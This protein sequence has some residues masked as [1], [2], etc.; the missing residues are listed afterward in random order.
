MAYKRINEAFCLSFC[1]LLLYHTQAF[2]DGNKPLCGFFGWSRS[3]SGSAK[4]PKGLNFAAGQ[5]ASISPLNEGN[6]HIGPGVTC[7]KIQILRVLWNEGKAWFSRNEE[8]AE[9]AVELTRHNCRLDKYSTYNPKHNDRRFDIVN[10][11]HGDCTHLARCCV[12]GLLNGS[13]F[14][15]HRLYMTQYAFSLIQVS[16]LLM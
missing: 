2:E 14:P 8:K 15:C 5:T 6:S 4:K 12:L 11:V 1:C 7:R 13:V 10:S 9:I 3:G 16:P